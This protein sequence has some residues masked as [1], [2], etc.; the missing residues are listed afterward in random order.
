MQKLRC[1]VTHLELDW[2]KGL[3]GSTDGKHIYNVTISGIPLFAESFC[4]KEAAIQRD[5]YDD[6]FARSYIENL[7]YPHTQEYMMY[8]DRVFKD[9]VDACD[10]VEFA[11]ICCGR[12]EMSGLFGDQIVSGVGVD[13]SP[14]MLEEAVKRND[15]NIIYVQGDATCLPL[16]C[17]EF[18]S[19]FMLGGVHHVTDRVQLFA[20]LYRI[21]QPGGKLFFREPVSDFFLWKW[22]RWIIYRI[23]PALDANTERPLTWIETVP[24]LENAG[25]KVLSWKTYGFLGF[26]IFMNS[27]VLIFNKAFRFIPGIRKLTRLFISFDDF[28]TSIP[29]FNRFGLQVVCVAQKPIES[30]T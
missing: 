23:S 27:D 8:L 1:P 21:M 26:C 24:L 9:Q 3:P 4:S 11:E 25:F 29:G 15:N 2:S 22:L 17:N 19:I 20:E 18:K 13:I 7:N 6:N 28:I 14:S 5:H 16:G 10:L 12:G 30:G